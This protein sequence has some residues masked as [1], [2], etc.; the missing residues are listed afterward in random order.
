MTFLRFAQDKMNQ[1]RNY[2]NRIKL[3]EFENEVINS[4]QT[5]RAVTRPELRN[6][7][8]TIDLCHFEN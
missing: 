8:N 4:T 7:R 1:K 2:C 3:T 5:C 6:G